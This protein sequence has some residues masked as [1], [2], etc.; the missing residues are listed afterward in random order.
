MGLTG[1]ITND[2][3]SHKKLTGLLI[4]ARKKKKKKK[5]K[6][7][8]SCIECGEE[9]ELIKDFR[10]KKPNYKPIMVKGEAVE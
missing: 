1:V 10:R 3:D 5:K 7:K 8:L 9:K 4:G 6:K 2:D